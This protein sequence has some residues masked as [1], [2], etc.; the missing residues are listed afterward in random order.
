MDWSIYYGG[1]K[2]NMLNSN[3]GG[4]MVEEILLAITYGHICW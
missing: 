3:V 2:Y 1:K 4:N